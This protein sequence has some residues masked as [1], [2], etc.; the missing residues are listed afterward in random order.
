[1][2][3]DETR[4]AQLEYAIARV[5]DLRDKYRRSG[6]YGAV[7]LPWGGRKHST[8][9]GLRDHA[10]LVERLRVLVKE[11]QSHLWLRVLRHVQRDPR[12][13]GVGELG[14]ARGYWKY[15]RDIRRQY[16]RD[17][18]KLSKYLS[19]IGIDSVACKSMLTEYIAK[20]EP[21]PKFDMLYGKDVRTALMH[22]V[23]TSTCMSDD[24]A[25]AGYPALY[26]DNPDKVGMLVKNLCQDGHEMSGDCF[27]FVWTDDDGNR[28][29]DNL[30]P[31][32]DVHYGD[33]ARWADAN[34]VHMM[35]CTDAGSNPDWRTASIT[36][37]PPSSGYFP[38]VDYFSA[39]IHHDKVVLRADGEYDLKFTD[40]SY[41][42]SPQ[43]SNC[44]NHVDPSQYYS[45][46]DDIY[47]EECYYEI[48]TQCENCWESVDR[49]C[50]VD[51]EGDCWCE[52]CA[53]D[54]ATACDHCGEY[55]VTAI[56]VRTPHNS[57]NWCE[58]CVSNDAFQCACCS[59]LCSDKLVHSTIE[60]MCEECGDEKEREDEQ[61]D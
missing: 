21:L 41:E 27:A 46:D 28:W 50:T 5:T 7:T 19:S 8:A 45:H 47:C 11:S 2:T 20:Y 34:N 22:C 35:C 37:R 13:V 51:V 16:R 36:L 43:C 15:A 1:M 10:A 31:N 53:N 30:Y 40:G 52:S 61:A 60:D 56:D 49:D 17:P 44:N 54:S 39:D 14:T 26:Y 29:L 6:A 23:G 59:D 3:F 18:I 42:D 38:Y 9:Q 24:A 12:R 4:P 32:D 57:Q 33:F 55:V 25:E 48:F 58:S